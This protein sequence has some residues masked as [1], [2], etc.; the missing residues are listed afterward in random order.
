[1]RADYFSTEKFTYIYPA[2]IDNNGADLSF[3]PPLLKRRLN[4]TDKLAFYL[5]NK[6]FDETIEAIIYCS[7]YGEFE[8]LKVIIEQYQKNNEISPNTFSSSTHNYAPAAFCALK[9]TSVPIYS[10]SG[11]EKS[12]INGATYAYLNKYKKVLYCYVSEEEKCFAMVINKG[13]ND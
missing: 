6:T 1:M 12:L 5:L 4:K 9:K 3:I 7:R 13:N 8:R 10:L 11:G 2:D